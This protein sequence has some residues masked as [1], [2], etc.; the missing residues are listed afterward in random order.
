MQLKENS[1]LLTAS[2]FEP[3]T[4]SKVKN[5]YNKVYHSAESNVEYRVIQPFYLI[6]VQEMTT[7]Y[8]GIENYILV[9]HKKNL[10]KFFIY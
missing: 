3:S 2:R 5:R 4:S 1:Q 10:Y 7:F 9:S 6:L 8:F